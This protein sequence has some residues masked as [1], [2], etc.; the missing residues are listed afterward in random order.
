MRKERLK[1]HRSRKR[2]QSNRNKISRL[3]VDGKE[4]NG[5]TEDVVASEDVVVVAILIIVDHLDLAGLRLHEEDV[6]HTVHH[7]ETATFRA[8]LVALRREIPVKDDLAADPAPDHQ[9]QGHLH[10]EETIEQFL[11]MSGL[12]HHPGSRDG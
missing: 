3:F 10:L 8:E 4:M 9:L 5:P 2:A 6:R 11:L 12:D 1:Q 7:L